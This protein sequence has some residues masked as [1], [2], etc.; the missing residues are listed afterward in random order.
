MEWGKFKFRAS[1][2][3]KIMTASRSGDPIGETCKKYLLEVWIR[4]T[5]G[6]DKELINKY[7]AKG[8]MCEENSMTLYCRNVKK[9]YKKNK[10]KFE[11]DFLTGTPDIVD[12]NT[13]IDIKSSWD[14]HTFYSVVASP[15]NKMYEYQLQSYMALTGAIEAKLVYCLVDTPDVLIADEV[16]RLKWKMGVADPEVNDIYLQASAYLEASLKYTDV[17]MSERYIEFTI[18]RND[19]LIQGMYDKIE[20]CR[21]Y[22]SEFK[23]DGIR[24]ESRTGNNF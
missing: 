20:L 15:I 10:E 22:L 4:E 18:L 19:K 8:N 21:E 2:V 23:N 14:I 16:N 7:I 24:T 3:G 5:Y 6:R 1:Q 9:F 11:N 17:P 12:G 13:V